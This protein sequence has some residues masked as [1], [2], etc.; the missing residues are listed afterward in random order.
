MEVGVNH[1]SGRPAPMI[2]PEVPVP[3]D[4]GS[5]WESAP[6]DG[7]G[8]ELARAEPRRWWNRA[9]L[10]LGAA[11]LLVGGFAA[12][13]QV[14]KSYGPAKGAGAGPVR[15]GGGQFGGR[16]GSPGSDA[17]TGGPG[18]ASAGPGTPRSATTGTVKLVDGT[19]VYVQTDSGEVVTVRTSGGTA[20]RVP[21]RLGDFKS[22]DPVSVDG[23]VGA[24]GTVTATSVTGRR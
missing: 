16:T 5:G 2:E 3:A 21:A 14:Q 19:T 1:R 12:G 15:G 7:L 10:W 24:D 13:A 4:D 17:G 8:A 23:A 6:D 9:T 11:L 18:G 20:V 22:G